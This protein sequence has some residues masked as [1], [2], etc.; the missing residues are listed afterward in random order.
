MAQGAGERVIDYLHRKTGQLQIERDFLAR[1][2]PSQSAGGDP[3]ASQKMAKVEI[4]QN[5]PSNSGQLQI[6]SRHKDPF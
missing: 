1:S 4:C 6:H 2:P 5:R 3:T